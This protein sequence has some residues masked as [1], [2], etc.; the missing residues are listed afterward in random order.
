MGNRHPTKRVGWHNHLTRWGRRG[1]IAGP[2]ESLALF[3]QRVK[4]LQ[5]VRANPSSFSHQAGEIVAPKEWEPVLA[6]LTAKLGL[7]PDWIVAFYSNRRLKP[8]YGAMSWIDT[9]STGSPFPLIQLRTQLKRG[10]YFGYRKEEV[11]AH[12]A[13]HALRS[14]YPAS[15]FEEIF[16]CALS[17]KKWRNFWGGLFRQPRQTTTVLAMLGGVVALHCAACLGFAPSWLEAQVEWMALLPATYLGVLAYWLRKDHRLLRCALRRIEHLFEC[18]EGG[19][20]IAFRLTDGEIEA[21]ARLP[22][23]E[24]V[25]YITQQTSLRWQQLLVQF[26]LKSVL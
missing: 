11:L 24:I 17:D 12:E 5:E 22:A 16:A 20:A 3:T 14:A 9:H 25:C 4:L 19:M 1:W 26:P 23:D 18:N 2:R 7:A 10:S 15:R 6:T 13:L 21:F 8:W